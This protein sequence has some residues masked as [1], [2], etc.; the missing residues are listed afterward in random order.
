MR[1]REAIEK[2]Y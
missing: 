1:D 2:W